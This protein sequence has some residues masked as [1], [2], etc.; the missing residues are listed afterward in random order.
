MQSR[1]SRNP[2]RLS[3]FIFAIYRAGAVEIQIKIE[4]QTNFQLPIDLRNCK[5]NFWLSIK[6]LLISSGDGGFG[7]VEVVRRNWKQVE[8]LVYL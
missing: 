3:S 6:L 5:N 7:L 4:R 1:F 8:T 2:F